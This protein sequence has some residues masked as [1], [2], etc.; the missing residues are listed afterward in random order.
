M[1]FIFNFIF[2]GILFFLIA[3]YFPEPFQ[4]LVSWAQSLVNFIKET[5]SLLMEKISTMSNSPPPS[6]PPVQGPG[7]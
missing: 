5:F 1:K 7:A 2:F 6:L 4:T 3:T